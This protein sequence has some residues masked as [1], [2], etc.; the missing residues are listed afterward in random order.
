[1]NVNLENEVVDI[2]KRNHL[3][4]ATA[5][6]CTG[7]LVAATLI[8]VAGVS[9]VIHESY[10]TYADRTKA[11]ILGVSEETLRRYTAV[12][13]EVAREMADG[14]C[15]VAG[16]DVGIA[17]TGIAGPDGGSAEFPVGLVYIGW[18]I[19]T[20]TTVRRYVFDGDRS[21]VRQAAVETAL[22]VL[23]ELLEEEG[24]R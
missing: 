18:R 9:D 20:R 5:E 14:V 3:T 13:P 24:Y 7:G 10:I 23:T 4:I 16:T 8:N 1:M 17:V 11:K 12:S 6:S 2:L 15:R 22:T 19:G 21:G